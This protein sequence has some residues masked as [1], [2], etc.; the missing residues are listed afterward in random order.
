MYIN[1]N[2]IVNCVHL[3]NMLFLI[4]LSS[5]LYFTVWPSQKNCKALISWSG[6]LICFL[7]CT[8]RKKLGVTFMVALGYPQPL[9]RALILFHLDLYSLSLYHPHSLFHS[10]CLLRNLPLPFNERV[11]I[12]HLV[13][14][15]IY[16]RP[17]F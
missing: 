9:M 16:V 6:L 10:F 3:L 12:V 13:G 1:I 4:G 14:K 11:F 5:R 15:C 17:W 8:R 2:F 7:N